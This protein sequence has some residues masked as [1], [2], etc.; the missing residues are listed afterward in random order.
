M[1]HFSVNRSNSAEVDSWSSIS[2]VGSSFSDGVLTA[3]GYLEV[4]NEYVNFVSHLLPSIDVEMS[5][6]KIKS[7]ED[8]RGLFSLDEYCFGL[9][10]P[11]VK[12]CGGELVSK[13]ELLLI[14]RLCLRDLLWARLEKEDGSY[15]T[16]GYDMNLYVGVRDEHITEIFSFKSDGLDIDVVHE[17]PEC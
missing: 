6:Y 7:L 13:C 10:D 8:R 4:E 9:D 14:V 12:L 16:F 3:E 15:I 1:N 2:D 17:E 11:R 5:G